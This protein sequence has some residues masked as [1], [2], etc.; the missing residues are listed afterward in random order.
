MLTNLFFSPNEKHRKKLKPKYY[1]NGAHFKY[2]ELFAKL[3]NLMT[4]LPQTRVGD[5]GRFF[6]ED[7]EIQ[8]NFILTKKKYKESRNTQ[9]KLRLFSSQPL[10]D[11]QS[12]NN[13]I[14]IKLSNHFRKIQ[15]PII[16][17]KHPQGLL[18]TEEENKNMKIKR[19]IKCKKSIHSGLPDV[20]NRG[21]S[22][23]INW[24][25]RVNQLKLIPSSSK[26]RSKSK[27]KIFNFSNKQIK[28]DPNNI[29]SPKSR[30]FIQIW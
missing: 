6:Q 2:T 25:H 24:T 14:K 15:I 3:V 11:T 1:E 18:L 27:S 22:S 26:V 16:L 28:V 8:N 7:P 10:Y 13:R 5:N 19:E 9:S 17:R 29:L 12:I 20:S 4:V 23:F 30:P 21:Y